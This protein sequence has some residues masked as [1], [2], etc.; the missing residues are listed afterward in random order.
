MKKSTFLRA[1]HAFFFLFSLT[2]SAWA[3]SPAAT[4]RLTRQSFY[5]D[6]VRR[7]AAAYSIGGYNYLRLRDLG[8]ILNFRVDF[9][10]AQN[11]VKISPDLPCDEAVHTPQQLPAEVPA[12]LSCQK[13]QINDTPVSLSAYLI[14]GYNY[15]RLRDLARALDF[16]VVYDGARQAVEL[17]RG[18]H[19][20]EHH[21]NTIIL[22][23]HAFCSTDAEARKA[24]KLYTTID[25]LK[26]NIADLRA[27]GLEP[28][29]LEDYYDG[30]ADPAKRYFIITID[31]GY[32]N[33]YTL[34]Y[35]AL[36]QAQIHADIFSV[37]QD[38]SG[39]RSTHFTYK[40][41]RE[42][43][44]SGVISIHSHNLRHERAAQFSDA[45]LLSM[46]TTAFHSLSQELNKSTLFFAY[47][48]GDYSKTSY[49]LARR[50][51]YKLQM[52][53]KR[54]FAADD[55]L[56]RTDMHYDTSVAELIRTAVYN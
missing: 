22:L 40:Q 16:S 48:Y 25:R 5:T 49:Q 11:T 35:P 28:L 38:L 26:Q 31:D 44:Q 55:I 33:N 41:A 32:L 2:G 14:G 4:G 12:F 6:D 9:D 3:S 10:P 42:M 1:F 29:S 37:V 50:A 13:V 56:V 24:P 34:A 46:M 20:F 43:E 15:F 39:G 8:E 51:G 17:D 7:T 18:A 21:N 53:Q 30:K 19:Y 54:Q 36:K 45:Q 52:V 47:P 27:H 23:Y